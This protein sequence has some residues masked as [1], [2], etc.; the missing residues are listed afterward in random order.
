MAM[1]G[2]RL[3]R[4]QIVGELGRGG[5]AVV[6]KAYHPALDRYVAIKVLPPQFAYDQDFVRRFLREARSAAAL[7][8]PNIVTI[9]DVDRADGY[10]FI[11]MQ[12]VGGKTLDQVVRESGRLPLPRIQRITSQVVDALEHAH[13]R[14]LIHRDIKPANIMVDD[15]RN[16]KVTLMD[17]GLV[18]AAEDTSLTRTGTIVGTPEYMSPEQ[19]EGGDIDHRTDIY[20]LGVVLFKLVTG[21]V[22]FSK[23]TP[24]AVL[25]A[26]MT[27]EPPSLSSLSP[28]VP[29]GVEAVI[30]KA[31]AKNPE[32]R[33]G[34]V[35][36]L[37]RDLVAASRGA[38]GLS[39]AP[40]TERGAN[41]PPRP[42]PAG[43]PL[44]REAAREPV[45]GGKPPERA[46]GRGCVWALVGLGALG[47]LG[48]CGAVALS[49]G[50]LGRPAS[51]SPGPPAVVPSATATETAPARV[52]EEVAPIPTL[53]PVGP[54]PSPTVPVEERE[55]DEPVLEPAEVVDAFVR[56]TLGTVPGAAVDYDRARALMTAA[57]AAEFDSPDF[58][59]RTYGIQD[60]PSNYDIVAEDVSATRGTIAVLGYWG[61]DPGSQW[62]FVLRQE[63]GQWRI[64]AIELPDTA[65]PVDR[66]QVAS[67]FWRLNPVVN[68]FTVRPDGGWKLVVTFDG[69][70]QDIRV[71]V[72][73]M[74]VRRDDG[75]LAYT[76]E[77]SGVIEAGRDRLTLDSDWSSYDLD[78]LGFRPG[79]HR[80]VAYFDDREIAAGELLVE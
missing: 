15:A 69:P 12:L 41:P 63:A 16:D 47:V 34:R 22:P 11:V 44:A 64:A 50:A 77:D 51:V 76:Q 79:S 45:V 35:R 43:S 60:G 8:H 17:F 5:M 36:E 32:A 78:Q 57:Y 38:T 55:L 61:G 19:A 73:M 21:R 65:E 66:D 70:S 56:A 54:A 13:E 37:G 24:H 14:G 42:V 28:D 48:L 30:R 68:E 29:A 59:P 39:Q 2:K 4:Y 53:T 62:H 10:T 23:S 7:H 20:S 67:P 26:H 9:H 80:V 75:T 31:L 49:L 58:V 46:G 3:G 71:Q 72:R 40:G 25:I 18:R 27:E 6:F 74:Y 52:S 1:E 33:Y